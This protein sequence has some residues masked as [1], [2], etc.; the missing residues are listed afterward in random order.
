MFIFIFHNFRFNFKIKSDADFMKLHKQYNV[1]Y[2]SFKECN[3]RDADGIY[4]D[5]VKSICSVYICLK[6][7]ETIRELL[8]QKIPTHGHYKYLSKMFE[9]F[10]ESEATHYDAEN[11]FLSK[12]KQKIGISI[13]I[14][15][16]RII[17]IG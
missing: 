1:I 8:K 10:F 15:H 4:T 2:C 17:D 9:K 11:G 5:F 14:S 6:D 13:S 3:R 7:C 12:I 16:L